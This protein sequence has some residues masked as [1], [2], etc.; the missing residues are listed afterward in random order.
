[1]WGTLFYKYDLFANR[2]Y[3]TTSPKK[4][5]GNMFELA[6]KTAFEAAHSIE[7]YKGKCSE[8]HG[9]NWK[10]EIII[11]VKE[12]DEY[13]MG[14]DFVNIKDLADKAIQTL[15]H[16]YLNELP[17]F[18]DKNSTAEHIA[19]YIFDM[20]KSPFANYNAELKKIAVWETDNYCASYTGCR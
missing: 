1:M 3:Q 11:E 8:L 5:G 2:T 12:L 6:I 20:L 9:H 13:G 10:V 7:G 15:D 18:K 17:Y 19:K 4:L 16:K 14:M